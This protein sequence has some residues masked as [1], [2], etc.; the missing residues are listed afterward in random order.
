MKEN[1]KITTEDFMYAFN[2]TKKTSLV[3]QKLES[4]RMH[5]II[6][7]GITW[8]TVLSDVRLL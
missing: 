7:C 6:N 4:Y 8:N 1:I 3:L 2:E 5:G